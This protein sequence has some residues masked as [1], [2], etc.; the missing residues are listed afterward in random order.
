ME[1]DKIEITPSGQILED[2]LRKAAILYTRNLKIIE[3]AYGEKGPI[4]T[5]VLVTYS[6]IYYMVGGEWRK[7]GVKVLPNDP[8]EA[9]ELIETEAAIL[10]LGG[11]VK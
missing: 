7:L 5:R 2:A 6:A 11:A 9:K 3:L 1:D 10:L 4:L 8:K